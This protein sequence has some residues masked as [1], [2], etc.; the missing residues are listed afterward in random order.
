MLKKFLAGLT[1]IVLSLGMVAL[2]AGPASAHHSTIT[3]T[4]ACSSPTAVTITWSVQNWN[5][6]KTGEVVSSTNNLVPAGTQFA[7]NE[8]KQYTQ[9]V[10]ST[11]TYSLSVTMKWWDGDSWENQT[12]NSGSI[13]VKTEHFSGCEPPDDTDDKIEICHSTGSDSNPYTTPEVSKDSIITNDPNG[14]GLDAD[15]IIPPFDY[16]KQGVAGHYDGKNWDAYGQAV[17]DA[18]CDYPEVDPADPTFTNAQCTGPGTYGQA[19][20]TIPATANVSY[21]VS[22]NDG[23][24]T[25]KSAGTYFVNVG[26]KVEVHAEAADGYE[27]DGTD[28]WS[29]TFSAPD[30]DE[31]VTPTKPTIVE[32]V[33]TGEDEVGD[34]SFTIPSITGIQYKIWDGD[35]WED[36]AAGV[37]TANDGDTVLIRAYP[38]AGYELT[39]HNS[40]KDYKSYVLNFDDIDS[41]ECD[42]PEA[43]TFTAQVCTG[44]GTTSTASYTIPSDSGITY[45]VRID[46]GS[47][48]NVSAGPV[49]VTVLPR[50]IEVQALANGNIIVP[51]STTSWSH[52]FTS[53][54]DCL[55]NV[56]PVEPDWTDSV[57]QPTT[58][59][60][61]QATYE[62]F[63][64]A[65]VSY[66]VSTNGVDYA[67]IAAG[68]HDATVGTT[69]WIKPVAT[70]GYQL[71]GD[72]GPWSHT[73]T[74]PGEC[75]DEAFHGD[76]KFVASI[77]EANSTGATQATYEIVAAANVTYQVS[78]DG[79]TYTSVGASVGVHDAP[80]SEIWITAI[81][82]PGYHILGQAVWHHVFV[83]P[84]ECLDDAP[85]EPVVASDQVCVLDNPD[86]LA[87]HLESGTITIPNT[88][89]VTY[90]V[91][92]AAKGAGVHDYAPGTYTISAV[93][94]AGY[95]L[96]GAP[97]P[98]T[99]TIAAAKVCGQL[100]DLPL[101]T[102]VV[103]FTQTT[104]SASGSYT[105][106]ANPVE[107]AVGVIWSVSGGLPNTLGTHVVT[108]PGTVTVTATAD[109]PDYG[110]PGDADGIIEWSYDFVSLP[111]DCLPTLALTG[112]S[113]AAGGLGL[114]AL[115]T[116][117]GILVFTA[118]KRDLVV[119]AE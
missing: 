114:G 92:A 26:T 19:S 44:P 108:T 6:G 24:W 3:A 106:A 74:D 91:D 103:T 66:E 40:G 2:T 47:W 77:C 21:T 43:P 22:I 61:T 101:V 68:V 98:W 62:V 33:C 45:Q 90:Y 105:L 51:G 83:D 27:I 42:V 75:L 18:D 97:D 76:P 39:D 89:H 78:T 1:T 118:R 37:Y 48:Q 109:G 73:F 79:V 63:L 23:S 38:L 11:G 55:V 58:T 72:T 31:E 12:T 84:G 71:S 94:E 69:V 70:S 85:V 32:A 16:I 30:C 50:L 81:A 117:G 41:D 65:N 80:G 10:A 29:K 35:S 59:G 104:C 25:A 116:L 9:T 67:P 34:A 8:T 102:P 54:G 87:A 99:V 100:P 56:E 113:I 5:G 4:A 82:D 13:K 17:Y 46:G 52:N 7:S 88:A 93:A 14:H 20:Y 36:I 15:D 111:D 57:C 96:T 53:A 119:N 60:S 115:L 95:Q 86:T 64:T 28:D 110:F 112:G 49:D 107:N